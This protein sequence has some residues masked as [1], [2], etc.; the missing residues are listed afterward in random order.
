MTLR[1]YVIGASAEIDRVEGVIAKLRE[2]G[3]IEITHDWTEDVRAARAAGHATD[4]ALSDRE[5][6]CYAM[7]DVEG[8]EAAQVVLL[9]A[10][11]SPSFGAGFE[12][13]LAFTVCHDAIVCGPH[14]RAS[15]FTRLAGCVLDTDEAGVAEVL[16]TRDWK[17]AV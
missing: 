6:R 15:I 16:R 17:R 13:G 5:A 2:A 11:A 14:A 8:V 12:L 1:V 9:L 3:G 7:N 4:A 10:P